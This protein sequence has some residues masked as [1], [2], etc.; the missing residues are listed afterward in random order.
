MLINTSPKNVQDAKVPPPT[1]ISVMQ[2]IGVQRC[3]VPAEELTEEALLAAPSEDTP[4]NTAA[5][6]EV[7]EPAAASSSA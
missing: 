6:Q 2:A 4:T 1:P 5:G 3:V 7:E